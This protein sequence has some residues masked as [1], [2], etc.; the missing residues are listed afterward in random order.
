MSSLTEK[1]SARFSFVM[2]KKDGIWKIAHHHSSVRPKI[3]SMKHVGKG[4]GE[5]SGSSSLVSQESVVAWTGH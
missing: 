5:P 2:V 1:Q 3:A 4:K